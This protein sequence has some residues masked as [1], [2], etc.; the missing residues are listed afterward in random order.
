[1]IDT[2]ALTLRRNM[3]QI[4]DPDKFT[5]SAPWIEDYGKSMQSIKSKQN[6]TKKELLHGIYKP[7]LTLSYCFTSARTRELMLRIE[8]SLPKLLYDNNFDEL[9]Y[10]DFKPSCRN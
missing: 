10:K 1:V 8:L 9:Q 2:L 5:P 7:R 3:F 6:P 4:T